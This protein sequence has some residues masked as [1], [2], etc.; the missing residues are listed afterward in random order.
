MKAGPLD[1]VRVVEITMFQQGPVAGMRLGDLGA[2][3]IKIEAK[4]GDPGRGFMKVIGAQVG[5]KGR[6]YYFEHTNRNKKSIVLDL[7]S[8]K[9]M[10]VFFKL[11]DTADVFLN[12][13]SIEAPI[14]L[15]IGPDRLLAR[16]PRLIYAQASGWGRK[17]PD[18]N[19]LSFDYTGIAPTGLMMSCGERGTPPAQI[20]PGMGDEVG[21]V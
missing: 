21:G 5:L 1:G 20:L 3:V 12:N 6:N 7:K 2:D 18:A 14:K 4:T 16:N 11:I 17:G 19:E 8:E 13:M 10:E 15:G 9:G